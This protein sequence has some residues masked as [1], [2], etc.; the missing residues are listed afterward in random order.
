MTTVHLLSLRS[1]FTDVAPSASNSTRVLVV[2]AT[3]R[4][5]RIVVRK[6]LLRGYTVR[7]LVRGHPHEKRN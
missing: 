1:A 6:L 4:V 5:G 3:G 7:A 2:G